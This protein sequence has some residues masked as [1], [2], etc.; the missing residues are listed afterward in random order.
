MGLMGLDSNSNSD[1]RFNINDLGVDSI[2][3]VLEEEEPGNDRIPHT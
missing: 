2:N 3:D 1:W